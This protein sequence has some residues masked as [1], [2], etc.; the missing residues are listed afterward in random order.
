MRV[1]GHS[2]TTQTDTIMRPSPWFRQLWPSDFTKQSVGHHG[3]SMTGP[4]SP[5]IPDNT[6]QQAKLR[7]SGDRR[8][9]ETFSH[10]QS[11]GA[12]T[13]QNAAKISAKLT[14]RASRPLHGAG[15]S[16]TQGCVIPCQVERSHNRNIKA[17]LLSI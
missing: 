12:P 4:L 10:K 6:I 17:T 2:Q 16:W 9:T 3:S 14:W 13:A 7:D 8:K 5:D 1:H 11:K 15:K